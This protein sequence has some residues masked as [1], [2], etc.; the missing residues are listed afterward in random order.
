MVRAQPHY[1]NECKHSV[2]NKG[3]QHVR[4]PTLFARRSWPQ[5][6]RELHDQAH[7]LRASYCLSFLDDQMNSPSG[8][9]KALASAI[10]LMSTLKEQKATIAA[11]RMALADKEE[12]QTF[13]ENQAFARGYNDGYRDAKE[14]N[15]NEN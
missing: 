14:E 8:T 3:T 5:G 2:K 12:D 1:L 10:N 11:L 9:P 7:E 13:K 4:H 15:E 6:V